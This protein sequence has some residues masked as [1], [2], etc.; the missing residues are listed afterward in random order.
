[1]DTV[2]EEAKVTEGNVCKFQYGINGCC[3]SRLSRRCCIYII[4]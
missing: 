3:S 4:V 1:M 2:E